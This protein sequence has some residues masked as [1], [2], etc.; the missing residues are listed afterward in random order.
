MM[1]LSIRN[2]PHYVWMTVRMCCIVTTSVAFR[3]CYLVSSVR[4]DNIIYTAYIGMIGLRK[5]AGF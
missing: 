3:A 4:T 1:T 2:D 5:W